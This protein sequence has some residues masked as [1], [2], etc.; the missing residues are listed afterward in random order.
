MPRL[1]LRFTLLLAFTLSS[2]SSLSYSQGSAH[3]IAQDPSRVVALEGYRA[4]E[5]IPL[6][7]Q[8]DGAS[9]RYR[10]SSGARTL[11][12]SAQFVAPVRTVERLVLR[13]GAIRTEPTPTTKPYWHR[14]EIPNA[15]PETPLFWPGEDLRAP[16]EP[17]KEAAFH[18]HDVSIKSKVR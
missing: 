7:I 9:G 14:R 5:W 8:V 16:D 13:T 2:L 4:A 17:D 3:S 1:L 15:G 10:V 6:E 12:A 18:V 11:I